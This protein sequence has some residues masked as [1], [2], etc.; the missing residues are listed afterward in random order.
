MKREMAAQ[1]CK[2]IFEL[3]DQGYT[4]T[5]IRQEVGMQ[6]TEVHFA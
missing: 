4:Y 2:R 1:R 5:R 3:L 6:E